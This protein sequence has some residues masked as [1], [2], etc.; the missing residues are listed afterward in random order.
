MKGA[1]E[2]YSRKESTFPQVDDAL[3]I[4]SEAFVAFLAALGASQWNKTPVYK[5]SFRWELQDT[6]YSLV[7]NASKIVIVAEM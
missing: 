5:T 2:F 1:L 7:R 6:L 4:I 3:K